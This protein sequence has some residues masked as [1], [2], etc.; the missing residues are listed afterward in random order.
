MAAWAAIL[1]RSHPLVKIHLAIYTSG[2]AP[3][4]LAEERAEVGIMTRDI[5]PFENLLFRNKRYQL[6]EIMAAGSSYQTMGFSKHQSV[7]LHRDNPL[8]KL[9]LDQLDAIFSTTRKRGYKEDVTR[10]GQLGLGG[11]GPTNPSI[12]MAIL[13]SLTATPTISSAGTFGRGMERR[14]SSAADAE[15]D[16][17]RPLCS[18]IR[19]GGHGRGSVGGR[20]VDAGPVPQYQK[21]PLRGD[22]GGPVLRWQLRNVLRRTYPLSRY[23]SL[24]LNRYPDRPVNPLAKEF[25]RVALSREGQEIVARSVFL[26]LPAR[27]FLNRW[28][29]LNRP[30][31]PCVKILVVEDQTMVR[32]LLAN[33]CSHVMPAATVSAAGSAAAA[34]SACRDAAPDVIL[35]DL[36]LPD[37]DGLDFLPEIFRLA[38]AVRVIA[39]S[40]HIDEFTLHRA[41]RC[42]VHGIL[43]KNEQPLTV[44]KEAIAAVIDGRQYISLAVLRLRASIRADPGAFD[45]ILSE[46][47]QEVLRLVG[48]G[49]TNDQI[50][51]Q[52]LIC[53]ATAKKHRLRLMAKLN[54]HSTPQLIRY[55]F[56]KGFTR[57]PG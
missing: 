28:R 29:R 50:A 31:V 36:V 22:H 2:C 38:P 8:G 24:V 14:D 49:L 19:S 53:A 45:K 15:C 20:A 16:G 1:Q 18:R 57:V 55:A 3:S 26:P 17:N 9:S 43:D 56:E 51:Q 33:E 47:E 12:F 30:A 41:I 40:S 25:V 27:R 5:L 7:Y 35:L 39:L 11:S 37:G 46:R 44:L 10:W 6:Q 13:S 34:L 4:A 23:T 54:M 42:R 21:R 32:E 48:D 52:L